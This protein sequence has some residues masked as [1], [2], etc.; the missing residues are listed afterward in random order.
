[1]I[2][3]TITSDLL[4]TTITTGASLREVARRIADYM[5]PELRCVTTTTLN[6]GEPHESTVE[7]TDGTRVIITKN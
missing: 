2:T 5:G 3:Y 4:T 6:W 7:R 1:M